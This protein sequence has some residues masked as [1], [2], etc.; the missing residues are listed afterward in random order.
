MPFKADSNAHLKGVQVECS[1][2]A[3]LSWVCCVLVS[4]ILFPHLGPVPLCLLPIA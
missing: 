2:L 3:P 4:Q 1:L